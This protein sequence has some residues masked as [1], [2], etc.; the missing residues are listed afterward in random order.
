M[1][2]ENVHLFQNCD[3]GQ[4]FIYDCPDGF[5]KNINGTIVHHVNLQLIPLLSPGTT[6]VVGYK[7]LLSH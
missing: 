7:G 3:Y 2:N 1:C 5:T 6:T 4:S